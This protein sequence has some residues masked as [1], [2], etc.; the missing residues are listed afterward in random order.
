MRQTLFFAASGLAV[1]LVGAFLIFQNADAP[2]AQNGYDNPLSIS[3]REVTDNPGQYNRKVIL[4]EG[5]ISSGVETKRYNGKD[6]T[7]FKMEDSKGGTPM[8]VYL[9]GTHAR[10]KTGDRLKVTGRYYKKRKYLKIFKLKNV[11]KG[12]KFEVLG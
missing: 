4:T 7:V 2:A 8:L 6:Y 3:I 11:L 1:I 9:R 5:E 12:R 10:L